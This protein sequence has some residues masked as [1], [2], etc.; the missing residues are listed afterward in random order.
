[1]ALIEKAEA[2]KGIQIE[3][4]QDFLEALDEA[5]RLPLD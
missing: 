5:S 3:D 2:E 1:M 4:I